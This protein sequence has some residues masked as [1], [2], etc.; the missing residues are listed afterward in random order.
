VVAA[1]VV[2]VLDVFTPDIQMAVS[3]VWRDGA[4]CILEHLGKN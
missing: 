4:L 1:S 3:S 2:G